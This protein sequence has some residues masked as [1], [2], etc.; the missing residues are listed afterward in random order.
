MSLFRRQQREIQGPTADQ[1]IPRR[2]YNRY[3]TVSVTP[4]SA[5]RHSAVWGCL[6]L[7]AN[8]I[9]TM[10]IDAFRKINGQQVEVTKR[11]VLVNP[12]GERVGLHEF[13]YSSQFDLDRVGN[14]FGLITEV[15]GDGL[16]NRIEL[17]PTA[18]VSVMMKNG[19]LRY[20]IG[21]KVY[22]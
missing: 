22:D 3:G 1:L 6:R 13:L 17:Q 11:P 10:P 18:T 19:V 16:P 9:S 2:T 21:K 20:R 15:T 7:R 4:D 5:L 14:C 8:V 12:G